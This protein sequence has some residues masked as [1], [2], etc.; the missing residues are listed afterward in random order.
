MGGYELSA[1]TLTCR[2]HQLEVGQ[3]VGT[4]VKAVGAG[5]GDPLFTCIQIYY[6]KP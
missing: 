6:I 1:V 3:G 2:E 5:E 4:L